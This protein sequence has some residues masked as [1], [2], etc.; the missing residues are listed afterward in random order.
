MY[1]GDMTIKKFRRYLQRINT[2]RLNFLSKLLF[3][4][5]SRL[6]IILCRLNFV[7]NPREAR[8]YIKANKIFI[9]GVKVNSLNHQVY[10]HDVIYF[11]YLT[12]IL[13][14]E[15]L[16]KNLLKNN[17]IFNYPKYIEMNYKLIK[18]MFISYPKKE[19]IPSF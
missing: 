5:E 14:N 2:R 3:L 1:Y 4:L 13:F 17:I 6:D 18:C 9:N 8:K 12:G 16:K 7:K 10:I 11:E 19:D 15:A